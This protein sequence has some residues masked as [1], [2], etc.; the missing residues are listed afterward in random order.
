[1][2]EAIKMIFLIYYV[3]VYWGAKLDNKNDT[4]K[5]FVK[6]LRYFIKKIEFNWKLVIFFVLLPKNNGY[7]ESH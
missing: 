6:F 3:L 2:A 4:T 5:H 7:Y 1:M